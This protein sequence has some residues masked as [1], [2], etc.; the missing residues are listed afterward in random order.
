M[1]VHQQRFAN[2]YR[3][4]LAHEYALPNDDETQARTESS[5]DADEPPGTGDDDDPK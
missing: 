3:D 5:A 4:A 1:Y 2:D